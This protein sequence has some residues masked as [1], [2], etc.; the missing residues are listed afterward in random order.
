MVRFSVK[1]Y[2]AIKICCIVNEVL[3]S[4]INKIQLSV[5]NVVQILIKHRRQPDLYFWWIP[6]VSS[7]QDRSRSWLVFQANTKRKVKSQHVFCANTHIKLA[8]IS[9]QPTETSWPVLQAIAKT[10]ARVTG[11]IA[12]MSWPVL[13]AY[14]VGPYFRPTNGD[15]FA[16]ITIQDHKQNE[17][18]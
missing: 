1:T 6:K 13:Q 16:R 3:L 12:Q 2:W 11:S 9:C 5:R 7:A 15:E 17:P 10:M 14:R 18:A 4:L 8:R